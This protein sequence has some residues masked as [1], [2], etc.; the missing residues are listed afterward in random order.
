V[1]DPNEP[2]DS[3]HLAPY[4]EGEDLEGNVYCDCT[5]CRHMRE[6]EAR[7]EWQI[8]EYYEREVMGK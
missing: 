5:R 6:K 2:S 7:A 1:R 8:D 3:D 4:T